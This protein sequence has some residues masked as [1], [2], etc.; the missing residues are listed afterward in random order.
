METTVIGDGVN[1][2]FRIE[3]MRKDYSVLFLISEHIYY[4]LFDAFAH[5][6]HFVGRVR[7]QGKA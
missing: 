6:V 5:N 3:S 2:A 7:A 1:L 4:S